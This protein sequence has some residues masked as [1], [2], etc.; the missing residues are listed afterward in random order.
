[1]FGFKNRNNSKLKQEIDQVLKEAANGDLERRVTRIDMSD[2]LADTAWGINNLLDQ[3]EAYM[4][5]ANS[6][7]QCASLGQNHRNMYPAGLKGLFNISSKNISKGVNGILVASKEKLRTELNKELGSLNGGIS[8]SF[9]I[10]QND[11]E[12]VIKEIVK[13]NEFSEKTSSKSDYSLKATKTLLEEL[14]QL[15][16]LINHISDAI[17]SLS[18]R[19]V[20]IT[21]IIGLIEEVSDQTNLLALN[22][23]IEAARAG[24]H[25]RGFAVVADEVRNLAERTGKATSEITITVNALQQETEDIQN[26]SQKTNQIAIE[27]EKVVKEFINTLEGLNHDANKTT[28][29]AKFTEDKSFMTLVKID[30]VVY[31]TKAYTAIIREEV[32]EDILQNEHDCKFGQWYDGAGKEMFGATTS[33]KSIQQPHASLHQMAI[34]NMEELK[35]NGLKN[36]NIELYVSN[37]AK[38]EDS[39]IE[40]FDYLDK[41]VNEKHKRG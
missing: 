8:A 3:L 1:M 24:E 31:K 17:N 23:A 14:T 36:S 39:S 13:I 41:A 40:L 4:R 5:D 20:D 30:H 16:E 26:N 28:L 38:M 21:A 15:I 18:Q 12:D 9:G 19:T 25:G 27:S 7:V 2:P 10:V 37:F 34:E 35:E 29:A 11:M 22:A 6:A 33:Y 32:D